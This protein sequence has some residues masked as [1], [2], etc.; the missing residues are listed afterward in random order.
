MVKTDG[1]FDA[2]MFTQQFNQFS[3]EYG[4]HFKDIYRPMRAHCSV[5]HRD[6]V[7]VFWVMTRY[8]DIMRV[9]R[10][11]E[12]FS[13]VIGIDD[14]GLEEGNVTDLVI[15]PGETVAEAIVSRPRGRRVVKRGRIVARDGVQSI[16]AARVPSTEA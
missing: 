16:A 5:A 13:K 1:H 11:Y 8:A 6:D 12:A 7:G 3:P 10:D 14:Y 4:P 15:L 2:A 9:A